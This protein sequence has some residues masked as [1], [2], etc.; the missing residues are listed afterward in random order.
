MNAAPVGPGVD[1]ETDTPSALPPA[2][3]AT[4]PASEQGR[5]V[6][7]A[8]TVFEN[9]ELVLVA[10]AA[11]VFAVVVTPQLWNLRDIRDLEEQNRAW[12]GR[13]DELVREKSYLM[14]QMKMLQGCTTALQQIAAGQ[15]EFIFR[16]LTEAEISDAKRVASARPIGR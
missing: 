15:M 14:E 5:W 16:R 13:V 8:R 1:G 10:A 6:A 4:F 3:P 9:R 7:A 2:K 12:A 11:I